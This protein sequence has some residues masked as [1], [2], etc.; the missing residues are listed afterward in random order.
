MLLWSRKE[1][2]PASPDAP[3]GSS[4]DASLRARD[5]AARHGLT[6]REEEVLCL[7]LTGRTTAYISEALCIS[8][9]TANTHIRHLYRKVGIHDRQ[10]L[11]DY[12][13]KGE[14]E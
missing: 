3:D 5:I 2:R 11:L 8:R 7:L 14:M 6:N 13:Y 9:N 12:A 10:E 1:E 4:R